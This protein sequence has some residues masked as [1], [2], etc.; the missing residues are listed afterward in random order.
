MNNKKDL[1]LYF[2]LIFWSFLPSIYLLVRM[3]IVAINDV[4]INILGQMEWFDLIDEII[5]TMLI[6]PLYSVLKPHKSNCN[7]V[8]FAF[9]ISFL[10]YLVFTILIVGKISTISKFMQAEYAT[11]YLLL[12]SFSMLIQ[13]ISTFMILVLTLNGDNKKINILIISKLICLSILDYIFMNKFNSIGASYSEIVT[14]LIIAIISLTLICKNK[15]M[16]F[17]NTDKDF[18]EEWIK[19][20]IP[21]GIQIF[22][23]NFIYAVM[24]VKMVNVVNESGNYWVANNFIWGWLLVPVQCFAEIIKKNDLNKLTFKNTWKYGIRIILCWLITIPFWRLFI[25]YGMSIDDNKIWPIIVISV[26]FYLTYIVSAFLDAWFVSKGN[27]KYT[28]YISLFVNILYYGIVFILFKIN[29]F[30]VNMNF[31]IIMFG[32]GMIVHMILSILFYAIE[33]NKNNKIAII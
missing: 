8:G 27:T 13:F 10:V 31:I 29:V 12:Q 16:M 1:K 18:V 14:N 11:L 32:I 24:I 28:M 23:D 5:T 30:N 22:L 3:K 6:V 15:Y 26:P 33:C 7:K 17:G 21:V 4:D 25:K 9:A 20:G 2:S 19:T